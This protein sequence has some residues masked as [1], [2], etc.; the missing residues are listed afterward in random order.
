MLNVLWSECCKRKVPVVRV[1]KTRFLDTTWSPTDRLTLSIVDVNP[2]AWTSFS[3]VHLRFMFPSK[4]TLK[5][6]SFFKYRN[7]R[8]RH[9]RTPNSCPGC[10]SMYLIEVA[11]SVSFSWESGGGSYSE[12]AWPFTVMSTSRP[13]K[14]V[15]IA[16]IV[17][18]W[19][20]DPARYN[21]FT[22]FLQSNVRAERV[23][24]ENP[25]VMLLMLMQEE[26]RERLLWT[27]VN[28]T[29]SH[30]QSQLQESEGWSQDVLGMKGIIWFASLLTHIWNSS[31]AFHFAK[32]NTN[33]QWHNIQPYTKGLIP[34]YLKH[35]YK[36]LRRESAWF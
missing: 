16:M 6:I 25:K 31:G 4:I 15:R 28:Q 23:Q 21:C 17:G 27:P 20:S 26:R 13:E 22:I 8:P 30:V 14:L 11:G 7:W 29:R 32:K 10:A 18:I 19:R 36:I 1:E 3:K 12:S 33:Q 34:H 9:K 5:E 35:R 2:S 24:S